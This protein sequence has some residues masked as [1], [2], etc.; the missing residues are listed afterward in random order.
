MFVWVHR[1]L[2]KESA[3][4]NLTLL[5]ALRAGKSDWSSSTSSLDMILYLM[6]LL[7][8]LRLMRLCRV[9]L[10]YLNAK[11]LFAYCRPQKV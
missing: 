7:L 8:D 5:A 9:P 10:Y 6:P 11:V 2:T 4:I 3:L 1:L